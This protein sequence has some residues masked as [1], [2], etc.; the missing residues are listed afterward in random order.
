[1]AGGLG[2]CECTNSGAATPSQAKPRSRRVHASWVSLGP[3]ATPP[4]KTTSVHTRNQPQRRLRLGGG[5]CLKL[6]GSLTGPIDIG[7]L[8]SGGGPFG[9]K[10]ELSELTAGFY[11]KVRS[12]ECNS[13][14][15]LGRRLAQLPYREEVDG[16]EEKQVRPGQGA[17][18]VEVIRLPVLQEEEQIR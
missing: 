17:V 1:M 9:G 13:R 2:L 10:R 6:S 18:S 7:R 16:C 5:N 8:N 15:P 14:R 3:V 12:S 11:R 4:R